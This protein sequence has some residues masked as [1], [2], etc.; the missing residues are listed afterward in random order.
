[1]VL[2]RLTGIQKRLQSPPPW[3][4][5]S[6]Q[7]FFYRIGDARFFYL[8]CELF[9]QLHWWLVRP[10][11]WRK[12]PS[13]DLAKLPWQLTLRACWLNSYRPVEIAW[14]WTLGVRSWNKLSQ[15]TPDS[16]ATAVHAYR[17]R[18]W[19]DQCRTALQL[20]ADKAALLACTPEL[21]RAPFI[22]LQPAE[23][24]RQF[25]RNGEGLAEQEI[26]TWTA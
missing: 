6:R 15:F 1:M 11:F 25:H 17:R 16:L 10:W 2:S 4:W 24:A 19:P 7:G 23:S 18:Y 20:L 26:P 9:Q 22:L 14:W 13:K 5:C 3:L 12:R 8:P 21:W